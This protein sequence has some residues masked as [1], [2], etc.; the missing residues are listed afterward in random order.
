MKQSIYCPFH[1]YRNIF[2]PPGSHTRILHTKKSY[3]FVVMDNIVT[4]ASSMILSYAFNVPFPLI[5]IIMYSTGILI[6]ALFGVQ[7]DSLTY[8]GI[9]V[10][11]CS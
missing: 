1:A 4:I 7:T 11:D 9:N 10:K 5:V 2:G 8:L 3:G 6:H